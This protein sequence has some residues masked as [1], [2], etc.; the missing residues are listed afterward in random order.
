MDYVQEEIKMTKIKKITEC[1]ILEDVY[2]L[3]VEYYHN[4]AICDGL[5]VH[6]CDAIRYGIMSRNTELNGEQY[7]KIFNRF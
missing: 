7:K 1:E 6:N 5:I 2:N 3:E 4:Y